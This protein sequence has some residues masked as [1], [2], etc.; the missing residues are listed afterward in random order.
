MASH[1]VGMTK[2]PFDDHAAFNR[3]WIDSDRQT[4]DSLIKADPLLFIADHISS[5]DRKEGA[6]ALAITALDGQSTLAV[7]PDGPP[8][9]SDMECL[10]LL[11]TAIERT[12]SGVRS[13]GLVHHRR[14]SSAVCDVDRRWA[15]ALKAISTAF[16]I[17]PM[18]VIARLYS[19]EIVRVPLPEVLPADYLEAMGA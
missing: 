5:Y 12:P 3:L 15:L 6:I 11:D 18:G 4:R 7:V 2:T 14:G 1:S 19:G 17:E 9:P 13:L 8:N 16:D 10:A